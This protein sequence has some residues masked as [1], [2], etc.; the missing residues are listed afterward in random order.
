MNGDFCDFFPCQSD[1]YA[2]RDFLQKIEPQWNLAV[3]A[4]KKKE[5]ER[6]IYHIS[7]FLGY[8]RA[9]SPTTRKILKDLE[10]FNLKHIILPHS[11]KM[12]ENSGQISSQQ[13]E[14]LLKEGTLQVSQDEGYIKAA[15]LIRSFETARDLMSGDWIVLEN[16]SETD[17]ITCDCPCVLIWDK[18][19]YI[20]CWYVPVTPKISLLIQPNYNHDHPS[21]IEYREIS[22]ENEIKNYNGHVIKWADRMVISSEENQEINRLVN[23]FRNYI[24]YQEEIFLKNG[25]N[26]YVTFRWIVKEI[27]S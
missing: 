14:N 26:S 25:E 6:Y 10:D 1:K 27:N 20:A 11:V 15:S 16:S 4:I 23:Q 19:P 5:I 21:S 8:L 7:Y 24:Q 17:F 12:A 18:N 2:I 22:I 3:E 13:R 9:L